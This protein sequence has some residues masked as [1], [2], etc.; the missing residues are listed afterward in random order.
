MFDE[1]DSNN[2][3]LNTVEVAV[4]ILQMHFTMVIHKPLPLFLHFILLWQ[5]AAL[6]ILILILPV[7]LRRCTHF[8]FVPLNSWMIL[9]R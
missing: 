9:R 1:D 8:V 6:Q 5:M 7:L 2:N 3:K 4:A